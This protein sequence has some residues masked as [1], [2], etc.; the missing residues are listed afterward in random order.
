MADAGEQGERQRPTNG[1]RQS[2][3]EP[4]HSKGERPAAS[5]AGAA[6]SAP[7]KAVGGG[8]RRTAHAFGPMKPIGPYKSQRTDAR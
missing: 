8:E 7:T 6:S 5:G 1:Q 3:V 2:G 4:P